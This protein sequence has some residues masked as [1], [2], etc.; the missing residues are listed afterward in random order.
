[1]QWMLAAVV[2][3][4][5]YFGCT[6]SPAVALGFFFSVVSVF[7]FSLFACKFT[8]AVALIVFFVFNA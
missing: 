6:Y 4:L 2:V 7:F 8:R 5:R 3:I 1:M